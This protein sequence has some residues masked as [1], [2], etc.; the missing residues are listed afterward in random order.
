MIIDFH[1]HIFPDKI[2]ENSVNILASKTNFKPHYL[3]DKNGLVTM[4][5]NSG[6]DIAVALPVVTN[7]KQFDSV[8]EYAKNINIEFN[9]KEKR[10]I[11]FAGIH[12]KCENIEEKMLFIKENGFLG[13]KIHPD[14]QQT[15][16]DDEGYIK[17]LKCA[18]ELD[19]IVVTHAGVDEGFLD[20]PIRCAPDRVLKVI[21]MVK[22]KKLVLG[23][24]GA[25]KLWQEVYDKLAGKGVY[26][27]T[28]F[29]L[30]YIDEQLFKKII[31]KHGED[32][33]LF[34]T[35]AP[36]QDMKDNLQ[37]IKSFNI[38]KSVLDKILYKNA[39]KLLKIGE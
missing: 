25:N 23:H 7:V 27:D 24:L 15:F 8:N 5:N 17:I 10:I 38:E 34:A 21:D 3:G 12:P 11:S 28:A 18:N 14:Y 35:D 29:T 26:F 16:I 32:K 20:A 2:A 6:V 9:G 39:C 1:T 19:L 30:N 37:R 4:L 31:E 33:I 13:V 36:W 22:P